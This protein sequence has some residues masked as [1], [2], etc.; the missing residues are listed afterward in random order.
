PHGKW[1]WIGTKTLLFEPDVRFPMATQYSVSVPAGTKSAIGGTLSNTKTWTFTTPPPIVKTT[2]PD[3]NTP[4]PLDSLMFVELDQRID[5]AEVLKTIKVSA[6]SGPVPLRLATTA[7]IEADPTLKEITKRAAKDP[8][9]A[10]SA[11]CLFP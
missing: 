8:W 4:R 9:V 10:V 2:Y 1:R 7:E 11:I 3:P 6:G 5:P